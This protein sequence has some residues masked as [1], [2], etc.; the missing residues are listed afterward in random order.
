MIIFA[1][2]L[3]LSMSNPI[4]IQAKH[5]E[6]LEALAT[7]YDPG[8]Y[9]IG[10]AA[11]KISAKDIIDAGQRLQEIGRFKFSEQNNQITVKVEYVKP[12]KEKKQINKK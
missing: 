3:V 11:V 12:A 9:K 4:N 6:I 8:I 5:I 10:G 2:L 1:K 7:S